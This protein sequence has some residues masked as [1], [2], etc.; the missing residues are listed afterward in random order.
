ME[1]KG[2]SL[3]Q[4]HTA[5]LPDSLSWNSLGVQGRLGSP[6]KGARN[7]VYRSQLSNNR[8]HIG[9]GRLSNMFLCVPQVPFLR[10]LEFWPPS[11]GHKM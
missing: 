2:T 10:Q 9:G 7:R 4:N 8:L 6:P 3:I 1:R 11:S 5:P